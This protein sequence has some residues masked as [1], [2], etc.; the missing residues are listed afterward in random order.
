MNTYFQHI[1]SGDVYAVQ[2][3]DNKVVSASCELHHSE[4]TSAN[5]AS[6]NFDSDPE[7]VH[8]INEHREEFRVKEL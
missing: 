6:Y 5:I 4:V 3:E 2:T 8:F 1:T 7:Q